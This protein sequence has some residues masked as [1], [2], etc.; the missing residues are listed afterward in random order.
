MALQ[1]M[2]WMLFELLGLFPLIYFNLSVAARL[3][4]WLLSTRG[5]GAVLSYGA[6]AALASLLMS[7]SMFAAD[8]VSAPNFMLEPDWVAPD[9][10]FDPFT[11]RVLKL[12]LMILMICIAVVPTLITSTAK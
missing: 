11:T 3:T 4:H 5:M 2:S 10:G 7:I 9:P 8:Q 12:Q 1:T 6:G